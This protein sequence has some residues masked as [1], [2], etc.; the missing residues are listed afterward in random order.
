MSNNWFLKVFNIIKCN[1]ST[2]DVKTFTKVSLY[3][4]NKP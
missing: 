3:T 4:D 1:V 2:K